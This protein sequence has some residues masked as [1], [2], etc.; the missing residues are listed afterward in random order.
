M[1]WTGFTHNR[2]TGLVLLDSD[3]ESQC[4]DV[5]SSVI[6]DVY[7]SY[8]SDFVLSDDIF[9]HDN[10]SVHT[11][12][13]VQEVLSELDIEMMIQSSY[14]SDLN[15]TENIWALMKTIIYENYS[16]LEKTSDNE[17]TLQRLIATAKKTWHEIDECVL[18]HLCESMLD[19]QNPFSN[20]RITQPNLTIELD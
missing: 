9:M 1:F 17:K 12:L 13:I 6:H 3:P 14:S 19:L 11:A 8:L 15:P 7:Q 4:D 20:L 10:V 16:E 2:Q 5:S 18:K